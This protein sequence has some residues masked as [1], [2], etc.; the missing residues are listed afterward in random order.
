MFTRHSCS[1]VSQ[2]WILTTLDK[3]TLFVDAHPVVSSAFLAGV[4]GTIDVA[5]TVGELSI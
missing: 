2:A 1:V 5:I 4:A 3:P